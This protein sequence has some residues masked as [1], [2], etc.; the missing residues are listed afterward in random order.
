MEDRPSF[1]LR[2]DEFVSR[3]VEL[4]LGHA[5]GAEGPCARDAALNR[6]LTATVLARSER[7]RVN[8]EPETGAV[9]QPLADLA[10][11]CRQVRRIEVRL[12]LDGE[13][14]ILRK[15]VRLEPALPKA[16]S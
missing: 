1:E 5:R 16:R 14:E 6:R 3:Q 15:A 13:I 7:L 12:G 11:N 4:D 9:E 10:E 8:V 2:D